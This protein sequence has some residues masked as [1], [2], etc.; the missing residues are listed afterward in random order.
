[1]T[2]SDQYTPEALT[3]NIQNQQDT[4][5]PVDKIIHL[6]GQTLKSTSQNIEEVGKKVDEQFAMTSK[7]IHQLGDTLER[8][9]SNKTLADIQHF[10]RRNPG[11]SILVCLGIGLLLG[12]VFR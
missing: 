4:K 10:V 12:R 3:S 8:Y 2:Y 9:E 11:K 6:T 5:P 7:N 1:M